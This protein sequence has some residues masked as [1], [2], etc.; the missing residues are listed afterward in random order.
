[1]F[2]RAVLTGTAGLK[3]GSEY[4]LRGPDADLKVRTTRDDAAAVLDLSSRAEASLFC[5]PEPRD[6][7]FAEGDKTVLDFCVTAA[8]FSV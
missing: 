5:S 6:L 1:M 2:A 3:P 7:R 4:E 8:G